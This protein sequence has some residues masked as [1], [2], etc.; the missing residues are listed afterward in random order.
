M[1]KLSC[2]Y[3]LLTQIHNL[4]TCVYNL[5]I[6]IYKSI[7]C[8]YELIYVYAS[9]Y[10]CIQLNIKLEYMTKYLVYKTL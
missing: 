8:I 4:S 2:K 7:S 3:D 6:P 10:V 5:V 9:N 1:L